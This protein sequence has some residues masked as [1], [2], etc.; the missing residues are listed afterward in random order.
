MSNVQAWLEV[1]RTDSAMD[2]AREAFQAEISKAAEGAESKEANLSHRLGCG[3]FRAKAKD[4]NS[5][6]ETPRR[7]LLPSFTI[8]EE[9]TDKMTTMWP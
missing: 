9:T 2:Y 4:P 6:L 8:D 3:L 5:E 1:D 7:Y